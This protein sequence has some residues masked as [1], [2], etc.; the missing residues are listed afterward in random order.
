MAGSR[1]QNFIENE[2][3]YEAAIAARI[4]A[5][6][7]KGKGQRWVAE[8]PSRVQVINFLTDKTFGFLGKMAAALDEWG[9][10][11]AGQE[12][13][14]RKIMDQQA[15]RKAKAKEADSKSQW[16]GTV[17]QRQEFKVTLKFRTTFESMYGVTHVHIMNDEAG[18]VLVHK[19]TSLGYDDE[20]GFFKA[21]EKGVTFVM[22]ATV[23]SHEERDG[24]KQTLLARPKVTDV[25]L[26]NNDFDENGKFVG[27]P[28]WE[29]GFT[30]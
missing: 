3:A 20:D 11:S 6:A 29:N 5:N 12:A 8:D 15:E 22:K 9:S 13:A 28:R 16:V 10:L 25:V 18:N 2:A 14:V 21:I 4:K 17:G 24:T 7:R 1:G 30:N 26:V 19:G 27:T 23:K